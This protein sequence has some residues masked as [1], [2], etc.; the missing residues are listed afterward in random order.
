MTLWL[1]ALLSL[2]CAHKV[3]FDSDPPGAAVRIDGKLVGYTPVEVE[4]PW[5]PMFFKD[6]RV[7]VRLNDHRALHTD[8]RDRMRL[9][10]PVWRAV[11][12]PIE[13]LRGCPEPGDEPAGA[14][15]CPDHTL[16]YVLVKEHGPAG[17]WGPDQVP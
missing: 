14:L 10:R 13:A 17:T 7:V 16:T 11:W 6:Y 1:A 15:S 4:V 8:I 5:R 12:H 3:V 9:W 2:G